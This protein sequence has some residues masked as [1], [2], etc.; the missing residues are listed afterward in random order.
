MRSLVL[1]IIVIEKFS[2]RG[3]PLEEANEH[4]FLSIKVLFWCFCFIYYGVPLLFSAIF[5]FS[6]IIID[7]VPYMWYK[8]TFLGRKLWVIFFRVEMYSDILKLQRFVI[9]NINM[10]LGKHTCRN[11]KWY[12]S[13]HCWPLLYPLLVFL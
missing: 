11:Y 5:M 2:A 4:C 13:K 6:S 1:R 9:Q 7:L 12:L 3:F 8:S 10:Q